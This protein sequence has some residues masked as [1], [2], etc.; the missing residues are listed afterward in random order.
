MPVLSKVEGA[1][2]LTRAQQRQNERFLGALARTGN[3]RLAAREMGL[4]RSTLTNA[5]PSTPPSPPSGMPRWRRRNALLRAR[6]SG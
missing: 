1:R 5:A 3:A 4:N 6:T 2:P